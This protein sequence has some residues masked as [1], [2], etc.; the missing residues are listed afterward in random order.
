MSG[1]ST[2]REILKWIEVIYRPELSLI[3][4]ITANWTDYRKIFVDSPDIEELII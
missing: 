4:E 1:E 2:K 3:R